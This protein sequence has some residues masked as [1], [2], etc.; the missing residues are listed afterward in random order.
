MQNTRRSIS[1]IYTVQQWHWHRL[2]LGLG[3]ITDVRALHRS[4]FHLS[5]K[6]HESNVVNVSTLFKPVQVDV[7]PADSEDVG[8]ELVGKLEKSEILKILNKF[9]QRR[10]IKSLCSENGLDSYLQQQAF[11]SFRRYCIEAENLPVDLHII[12][13]DIMQ[14]A[15]HIDDI[16]PYFLRH[17]KTVFPHLD[18]MDDLKKI[19]DLRQPA[20]WYTNARAITRK[21]VFH[22]GPTNSGKTYHA[23]ERYLSAKSGVYCGPLKLLATEVYN[24]ANERGTPCD[25]VTGEERKFGISENSPASHVACTVEMTSVNTPYEVAVIDEIQ[26]IRDPQRGWAWTRAFLGLIADEVH[27]CGEA[28]SLELLEKICETTG[29]TVEVRRYDRLTELTV[30]NTALGSLDNVRPGDCI[31]CFSK[32]D[33]YTVSREIEARGKEVAVIYG[34]LPPGTKL[35]QAAKFN[36]PE[37]SCKVMV[38]T[39]AIGMGLN[40]SIRRIIF[41][42]LVKPTLNERGEREIDTI[43]V[44]AALQIAG[45]AGRFRTQWEHGYVTA[46]KADDLSTL[47][48]ILGQTPEPLKQAGL[49]PTADQIELYAYHLPNSSLSNLMDIFVNLCTVDDSLYFMCNIDDFKFLAEMIQHV[50]LPLRARYVFCCAPINRKMPFVCSMFLKIARQYSRNEPITFDFIKRNCGWPFKLPKTILDLVHL[51]AIFDVMD[52]YL[53]LSYRFMDLFPEAASVREAQKELDEIIQQGVFQITRLLKN[54]EADQDGDT[55]PNYG[56]RRVTH[57][58]EPR[59]PSGSRGRLTERLLAQGLLT[60]GMLSE[61]RKEWNAQAITS[62]SNNS[63]ETQEYQDS[64]DEDNGGNYKKMRRKRKK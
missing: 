49:H 53:W 29:E 47:Q 17:A 2:R 41:Y 24:K 54:T 30:E 43:S 5:R 61:L 60:P 16:F 14:G 33:I 4:A 3:T 1:L 63:K 50:P 26:Q 58:K 51:E 11:G 46:F 34:G 25:L 44:S 7:N 21:I 10:E 38:A 9:T 37:N 27:V 32:H 22:A 31:V 8:S 57:V 48:R 23:M 15:G 19:S 56:M 64:D 59:L 42:S 28:G 39:D 55:V 62:H 18:C 20:N 35:A 40:L 45:R 6:K 12:F 36:D 13:S 52:L